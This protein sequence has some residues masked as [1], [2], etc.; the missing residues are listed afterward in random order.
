VYSQVKQQ[1]VYMCDGFGEEIYLRS[2]NAKL[3]K[4]DDKQTEQVTWSVNLTYIGRYRF[5]LCTFEEDILNR[6]LFF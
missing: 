2:F 3:Y 1:F 6:C 4:S 5:H